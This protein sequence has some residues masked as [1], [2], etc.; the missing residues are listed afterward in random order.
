MTTADEPGAGRS[1]TAGA[2]RSLLMIVNRHASGLESEA[3]WLD[4]VARFLRAERVDVAMHMTDTVEEMAA[5]LPTRCDR[6]VLVG[7]DGTL[8]AYAN[9]PP[10]LGPVA[11]IP[12]GGANNVARS[13]G[14][15]V[16]PLGAAAVAAR[17]R[18]RDLDVLRVRSPRHE[19][20]VVEGVSIGFHASARDGYDG[21][22]SSDRL[23]AIRAGVAA[24]RRLRPLRVTIAD[25][26]RTVRASISQLFVANMPLYGP[27]L[28]V[29]PQASPA[30]GLLDVVA[31]ESLSRAELLAMAVRLRRGTQMPDPRVH[32]WRS[33]R[34]RL[35]TSRPC[36]VI[37]DAYGVGPGP[38]EVE[39]VPGHLPI[40]CG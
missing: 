1:G 8:H 11:L 3:G 31:I 40:A 7:G 10:P 37:A 15:P 16:D 30:D 33:P 35:A 12:A 9:L 24:L 19:R 27:A 38:I 14:I 32:A 26:D 4:E 18:V 22:N 6:V 29:A 5:L 25:A 39:A 23:A 13:L 21:E 2:P 17:G 20:I 34:V 28:E 36:A